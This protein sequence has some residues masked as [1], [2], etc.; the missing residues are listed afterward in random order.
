VKGYTEEEPPTIRTG[1]LTF[2]VDGNGPKQAMVQVTDQTGSKTIEWQRSADR[3]EQRRPSLEISD[4]SW[5]SP[6]KRLVDHPSIHLWQVE[7]SFE[8]RPIYAVEVTAPR[9]S[10][11]VSTHKLSL[12]KP[13]VLIETGH[14]PNEVSSMPAIRELVEE[15]VTSRSEWLKRINLVV[16]PYANPDGVALHRELTKDNPEWK[17]H[18]ARYNAVGLEYTTHR[19]RRTIFGEA[20]VVPALFYRW[21]PDVIIDDHGIP[22]HEWTQPFTG[23]NSPPRFP[24]S[25]WVPISLFYGIARELD[26]TAYPQHK[27]VLQEVQLAIEDRMRQNERIWKKNKHYVDRYIRYGHKWEPEIFPLQDDRELIFYRWPTKA[28]RAATSLI[29]RHPEWCTL[30]LI[31]EAADETVYGEAL[32]DCVE[33]H[34]LFDRAVVEWVAGHPQTVARISNES[35]I[36]LQRAR[37]L[38]MGGKQQ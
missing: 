18:A 34:K 35:A 26:E 20:R 7:K 37:P 1:R 13:T 16:I 10:R 19:F 15:I 22:S 24:V 6:W 25:Y 32:R 27:A 38:Q 12:Y 33:A 23:Y 8:K 36:R 30:D 14:H 4:D 29:S 28:D 17:H 31:T 5:I 11:F 2:G 9:V 21:L 3:K